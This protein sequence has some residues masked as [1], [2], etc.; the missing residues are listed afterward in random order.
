MYHDDAWIAVY[1][2]ILLFV[3]AIPFVPNYYLYPR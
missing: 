1:P 3:R 2:L